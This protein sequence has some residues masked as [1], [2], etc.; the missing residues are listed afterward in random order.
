MFHERK[1]ELRIIYLDNT[2]IYNRAKVELIVPQDRTMISWKVRLIKK[3]SGIERLA[4]I[5]QKKYSEGKI[6]CN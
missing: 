4:L 6:T 1:K 5:N 3:A 2:N